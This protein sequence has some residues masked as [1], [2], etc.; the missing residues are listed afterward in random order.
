MIGL[1][2]LVFDGTPERLIL[3]ILICALLAVATVLATR[4]GRA[5][6]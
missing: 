5:R 2:G 4:G 1:T 6:G 3:A